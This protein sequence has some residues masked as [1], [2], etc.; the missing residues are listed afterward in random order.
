MGEAKQ[1]QRLRLDRQRRSREMKSARFNILAIGSRRSSSRLIAD[2]RS[3]WSDL[4]ERLLGVVFRDTVDNDFGW[5]V[6][7]RDKVGRFRW[8]EGD[9]SSKSELYATNGLRERIAVLVEEGNYAQLGD[10]GDETNYPVNLLDLAPDADRQKLHPYFKILLDSPGS[11]PSRAV[12]KEIGPWLAPS[13][14]HFVRE[15]QFGQF[16]QRLWEL[17]LWAALRE[18]GFDIEQPEAPDFLCRAPG[19]EFAV[20]AT[21]VA[22]SASGPL[23]EHPNPR[24]HEEMQEFL[25]HYMPMKFGSGLTSK[26]NKKNKYGESYWERGTTANKPFI[27]AVADFHKPAKPDEPGSMTY[28]QSA[29]WP[30]LY[31]HRVKWDFVDGQLQIS[32]IRSPE[33]VY[34]E[35]VVPSGFFDL[36]GAE[37]I[38]AVLFSNAGTLSKFDRMGVAAGYG[39]Q[40]H[41]YFRVGVRYNQDPN[42][43]GPK[44]FQDEIGPD[45]QEFWSDEIQLFHNPNARLPLS[46]VQFGVTQHFFENGEA[47][48]ITPENTV[49]ASQTLIVRLTGQTDEKPIE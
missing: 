36:P 6:L 33:H 34:R 4:D 37:N 9:V 10:Q 13:D 38:S 39:A 49:L 25:A 3:Y 15:F 23:S 42:A 17:Y 40:D 1:K 46:T 24:T 22:A 18:L 26:L 12:F 44:A 47:R 29:L 21:T 32:T 45:Y 48:S 31:G 35:K 5:S 43:I 8:V 19:I 14:P 27:L 11:A 2:E 16:N 28:T 7:A 30:Y 41:R 20:E